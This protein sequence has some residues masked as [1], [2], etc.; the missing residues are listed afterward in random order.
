[1]VVGDAVV[2]VSEKLVH[3]LLKA[4]TEISVLHRPIGRRFRD[5]LLEGLK[6]GVSAA[7]LKVDLFRIQNLPA[8][9]CL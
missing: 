4:Q 2:V 5:R 1:M 9:S 7:N 3:P 8:L 6:G